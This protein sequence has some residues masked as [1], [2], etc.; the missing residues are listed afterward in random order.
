MPGQTKMTNGQKAIRH[1]YFRQWRKHRGLTQQ[2]VAERTGTT[3]TSVSRRER[4]QVS[5][6]QDYLESLSDVLL[7][8]AAALIMRDPNNPEGIW[9]IWDQDKPGE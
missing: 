9:S 2:Q 6:S 4:G 7:T 3:R 1:N 5:Y 8:N